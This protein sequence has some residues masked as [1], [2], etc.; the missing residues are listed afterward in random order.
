MRLLVLLSMIPALLSAQ[1]A[2]GGRVGTRPLAQTQT[3]KPE[4]L[5]SIEGQV[6][7]AVT[8]EIIRK[9]NIILTSTDVVPS[10]SPPTG[11]STASDSAGHFAMKDIEPGQYR[12]MSMRNG[13]VTLAYGARSAGRAG[14]VLSL[15]RQQHLDDITLKMTP[16]AV[17][18][19]RILD[20][21]GEPVSNARVMLQS[22][23]YIQGRKQLSNTGGAASTNDLGEYRIFGV[24][25]GKYYLSVTPNPMAPMYAV[26]RSANAPPEEDY[27]ATY[28]PSTIDPTAATQ[29]EV[30]VG[31]QLRGIDMTLPKVRTVHVRGHITYG[32]SGQ[33]NIQVLLTPRAP[34]AMMGV[35]R[36]NAVNATG[37][38]DIRNVTPGAYNLIAMANEGGISQ[39]ARMPIDVGVTNVEGLNVVIGP[40]IRVKGHVRAEGGSTAAD[41]STVRLSL[42]P[43]DPGSLIFGMM[44]QGKQSEEGVFEISNIAPDR[45]NFLISGLAKGSYVKSIHADQVDVLASGLDLTSGAPPAMVEVVISPKAATVTGMVQN[46]NTGNPTPG[47]T[48]VLIPQEKERRDQQSYYKIV[49]SDQNG[50]FS[51]VGVA[52]GEYKA[53][54]WEDLE[55]GAFMDADFMKP[56]EEK[57]DAVSLHEGDQKTVT[58]RLIPASSPSG[59]R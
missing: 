15:I 3:T 42:Q 55:A 44:P 33:R 39:Q 29:L 25:P 37:N 30:V 1:Q 21:E 59:A 4:D 54:A 24:A 23:R 50:A 12:L 17:V 18:I 51:L 58:L 53:Y 46:P 28:Y 49:T 9:A 45:Y 27:V 2:A 34:G 36:S 13:Y 43:R 11:Y 56:I 52:P 19:G 20:D 22:Y 57:G 47:A 16:H 26:D 6:T 48:V 35:V 32:L 31:A 40:G 8:G 5:C 7:N 41:L 14:T 10:N 38:F